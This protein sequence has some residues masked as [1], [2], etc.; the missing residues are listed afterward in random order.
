MAGILAVHG[1]VDTTYNHAFNISIIYLLYTWQGQV[2]D[3]CRRAI[4]IM[5]KEVISG[6]DRANLHACTMHVFLNT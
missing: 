5:C 2:Q 4:T 6:G 3:E 1:L